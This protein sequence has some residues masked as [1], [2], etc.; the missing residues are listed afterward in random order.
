[1]TGLARR[2][3]LG[4]AVVCF[5]L[6][7][8]APIASGKTMPQPNGAQKPSKTNASVACKPP[9]NG[10]IRCTMTIKQGA[11]ISGTVTMR[12]TR[13]QLL[14]AVGKGSVTRGKAT[15]TMRVLHKMTRGTPY[16]VSMVVT[17]N[18]KMVLRLR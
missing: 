17:L 2:N 10:Q 9:S 8:L 6:A 1:M 16:T 7:A 11:G 12:I 14:V 5:A 13:G 18:A 3:A 15:L 4:A